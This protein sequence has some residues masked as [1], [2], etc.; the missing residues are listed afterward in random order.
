M[1]DILDFQKY[2]KIRDEENKKKELYKKLT[3]TPN[4]TINR[5][6][7]FDNYYYFNYNFLQLLDIFMREEYPEAFIK[8][9]HF[10]EKIDKDKK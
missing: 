6:N 2:K 1:A 4:T 5:G 7:N 8:F 9:D 10:L 3:E